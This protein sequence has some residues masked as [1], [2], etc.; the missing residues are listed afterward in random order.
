[1]GRPHDWGCQAMKAIFIEQTS[2]LTPAWNQIDL[3]QVE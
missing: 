2:Q 3:E 1:M